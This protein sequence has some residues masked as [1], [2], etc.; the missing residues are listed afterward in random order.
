MMQTCAEVAPAAEDSSL[1]RNSTQLPPD[2]L[3]T[4]I[5]LATEEGPQLIARF[6]AFRV[7]QLRPQTLADGTPYYA[8]NCLGAGRRGYQ[9]LPT[10][11]WLSG[12]DL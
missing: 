7:A 2:Q 5:K 6:V 12:R 9:S 10:R 4:Y 8:S 3:Q 1:Y 11:T